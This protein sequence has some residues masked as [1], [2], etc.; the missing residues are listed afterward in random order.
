MKNDLSK[1]VMDAANEL[2]LECSLVDEVEFRSLLTR[3]EGKFLD[4][5]RNFPL[6][7]RMVDP[8]AHQ[9]PDAWMKLDEL[10]GSRRTVIF[11]DQDRDNKAVLLASGKD[12]SQILSECTGF[13][14]YLTDLKGSYL[15][16]FN[17]H[18]MHLTL[19]D[20]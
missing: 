20:L 9:D 14:F 18:D 6:W 17:D 1:E 11:F 4:S 8:K 12:T 2:H 7:E 16:A 19:G 13:I 15:L 3:I 5:R 10:I